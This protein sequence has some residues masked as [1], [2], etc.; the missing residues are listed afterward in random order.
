MFFLLMGLKIVLF[1]FYCYDYDSFLFS[2]YFGKKKI[3]KIFLRNEEDKFYN[4][5]FA[6]KIISLL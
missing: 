5:N 3:K 2:I 6:N 1:N 4:Y